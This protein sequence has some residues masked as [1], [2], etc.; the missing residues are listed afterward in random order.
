MTIKIAVGTAVLNVI[1]VMLLLFCNACFNRHAFS[2]EDL[3]KIRCLVKNFVYLPEI[4]KIGKS[5]KNLPRNY[6]LS[7][8]YCVNNYTW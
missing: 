8:R 1:S 7:T 5:M 4:L 2:T 3:D 6:I